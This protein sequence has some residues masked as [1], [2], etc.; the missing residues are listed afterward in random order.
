[1]NSLKIKNKVTLLVP[2]GKD[3]LSILRISNCLKLK[4]YFKTKQLF[5][6]PLFSGVKINA[7]NLNI[8]NIFTY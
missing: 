7:V 2:N 1:M 6:K 8:R 4:H 3:A 5:L